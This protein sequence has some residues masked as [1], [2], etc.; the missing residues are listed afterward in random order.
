[1]ADVKELAQRAFQ[2]RDIAHQRHWN[3]T[4][5]AEHQALGDFYKAVPGLI[6]AIVEYEMGESGSRIG[7]F[8]VTVPAMPPDIAGYL[9]REAAWIE[10]N[11]DEIGHECDALE[12]LIDALA[13][14]YRKT[15]FLLTLK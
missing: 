14:A 6:D 9:K 1:M 12:N 13:E 15:V 5:Y 8:P 11:R 4:S 7:N 3:T 10:E 2:A